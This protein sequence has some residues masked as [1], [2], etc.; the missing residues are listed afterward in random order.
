MHA[1]IN[2][3]DHMYDD[4]GIEQETHQEEANAKMDEKRRRRKGPYVLASLNSK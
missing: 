3:T 2:G 1:M 4:L